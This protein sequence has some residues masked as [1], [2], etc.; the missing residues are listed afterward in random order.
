MSIFNFLA[1]PLGYAMYWLY[2]LVQNYGWTIIIFTVLVRLAM[3]PLTLQ[4]QKSTAKTAAYQPMIQEIQKKWANDKTRQ[5][6]EM[7][8]FYE[9][10]NIK[11]TAG[12]MPMLVNMLIIFGMIAVIQSPLN[13][14]LRM[15]TQQVQV[16]SAIVHQNYPDLGFDKNVQTMESKLI[17]Q[18]RDNPQMFLEGADI[19]VDGNGIPV[20]VKDGQTLENDQIIDKNGKVVVE[21]A[22]VKH[23]SVDE[24]WVNEVVNFKFD[25]LGLNLSASPTFTFNLYLLFPILSILTMFLSQFIIM[26]TSGQ[27]TQNNS[28]MWIMTIVMGAMFGWYAFTAPVGFSLYY[29]ASNIVTTLQQLLVRRLHNPEEVKKQ[30]MEELEEK[31]KAKKA[32]KS[33][34]VEDEEG[35]VV[36][37]EMSEADLAKYRLELARKKDA[38]KYGSVDDEMTEEQKQAAE[39]AKKMDIERYETKGGRIEN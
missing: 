36:T 35:K 22:Q 26:K 8:K 16:A 20:Y 27:Q 39:K 34:E 9:E 17:G 1:V 11:M 28:T 10:N 15:P 19:L 4:Q 13:H 38:E 31:K 32:K 25:F 5:S 33:V 2:Q 37:K 23:V 30:I 29:A 12:C 6:Q 7:Q 21:N 18:M 3:F 14:I 24:R